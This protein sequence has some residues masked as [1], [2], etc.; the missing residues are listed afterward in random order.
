MQAEFTDFE[1][2][3]LQ[4]FI[5]HAPHPALAAQLR[6]ARP[7][8]REYT[9]CGLY[10]NLHIDQDQPEILPPYVP[11]PIEGPQISA[12][13]LADG[14]GSLLFHENGI[15]NLL[16]VYAFG[17]SSFEMASSGYVIEA[18]QG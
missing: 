17:D 7:A 8:A 6:S 11:R 10:L 3:L 18:A 14:A 5:A 15:V 13:W 1:R 12:A 16:E 2:D 4:W 9:G